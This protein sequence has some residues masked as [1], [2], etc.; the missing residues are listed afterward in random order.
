MARKQLGTLPSAANDPVIRDATYTADPGVPRLITRINATVTSSFTNLREVYVN[1][2]LASWLNEWGALRGSAQSNSKFDALVRAIARTDYAAATH[3]GAG[4]AAMEL[5]SAARDVQ[6]W[7]R[8]WLTGV[9]IRYGIF[10]NDLLVWATGKPD[11]TTDTTGAYGYGAASTGYG[12]TIPASTFVILVQNSAAE[13]TPSW[14]PNTRTL[15]INL[16]P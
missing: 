11:P 14:A 5:I 4:Y 3:Q 7:G 1:G 9:L 8:H 6:F 10:H 15:R 16:A 13:A 12:Q 2:S